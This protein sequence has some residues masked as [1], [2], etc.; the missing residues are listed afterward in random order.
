MTGSLRGQHAVVTG[1]GRGLGASIAAAIAAEGADLTLMGRTQATIGAEAATIARASAGRVR[2]VV[3]DVADPGSVTLAFESAVA[4]LGPVQVLVNNAGHA[5][6]APLGQTTVESWERTLAVNLTGTFLCIQQVLAAMLAARQGR[7]VN[8]ASTAGLR[9]YAHVAAY[10]AAKHGVVGL[11]RAL[12]AETAR[13]GVTVNAVCPGYVEGTPMLAAALAGVSAATGLSIDEARAV[14][15]K[16]SP[17]GR[18]ATRQEVAD[19]VV[20][21]CRPES[22][23]TSGQVIVVAGGELIS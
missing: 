23:D 22:S 3:C 21:L 12:A 16:R 5:D 19:A 7:I 11:T 10:C 14:L 20:R 1:G 8:V 17:D 13:S 6:A 15:A 4:A 2:A 9:G 18:L